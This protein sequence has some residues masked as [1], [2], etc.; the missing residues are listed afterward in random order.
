MKILLQAKLDDLNQT[1]ATLNAKTET[2]FSKNG[3]N[4]KVTLND[5]DLL[6]VLGRGAFGKVNFVLLLALTLQV[7]LVEKKDTK[8]V[9][10]MKSLHKEEIIDKDQIEH[11]KTERYVLEKSKSPFLV[12]LEFAFQTPDKIFFIMNFMKYCLNFYFHYFIRGGE[13]FQHLRS[14]RRFDERRFFL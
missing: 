10:A 5:F 7:M 4:Q 9:Y 1:K 14:S 13:L 11:T 6:K 12:G 2:V 3:G 8:Q